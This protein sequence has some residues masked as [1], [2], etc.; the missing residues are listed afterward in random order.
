MELYLLNAAGQRIALLSEYESLTWRTGLMTSTADLKA[1]LCCFD[2][3]AQATYLKRSDSDTILFINRKGVVDKSGQ[4]AAY[5]SAYDPV[6]LLRRRVLWRTHN[7][8]NLRRE[9]IVTRLV[10]AATAAR[11][12]VAGS[13]ALP[14]F[15]SM[16]NTGATTALLNER[17]IQQMSWGT[18]Y[19]HIESVLEGLP[20]RF[21]S[22]FRAERI[23]PLLYE[24]QD[25][26]KEVVVSAKHG[27]LSNIELA[28]A[29]VD[30]NILAV[31]A[32]QGEGS[33]RVVAAIRDSSLSPTFGELWVDAN[34]IGADDGEGGTIP[35]SQV[36]AALRA[37]GLEKLHEQPCDHALTGAVSQMRFQYGVDYHVGDRISYEVFGARHSDMVSE[38]EEVFEGQ[39]SRTNIT[40]GTTY[41]T[42]RQILERK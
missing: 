2:D 32:G 13:R 37:R 15:D 3:M 23:T 36:V 41:P 6:E 25:L 27:D 29:S 10:A 35:H 39:H 17:L 11:P 9:E 4:R 21:F 24:G 28:F 1:P 22:R 42:I 34:D 19:E 31:V 26:T 38:V 40:I 7:F 20:L 18:V 16:Q 33:A 8:N 30:R 5:L 12:E 14:L